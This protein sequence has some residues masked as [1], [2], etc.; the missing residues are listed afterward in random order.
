MYKGDLVPFDKVAL[1]FAKDGMPH[2]LYGGRCPLVGR[3]RHSCSE[4]VP[5]LYGGVALLCKA[6]PFVRRG[7]VAFGTEGAPFYKDGAPFARMRFPCL[8][9]A[10][11]CC[12]ERMRSIL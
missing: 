5:L 11:P 1:Q 6:L 2:L 3:A 7:G 9:K 4:D 10:L 12:K 8:R